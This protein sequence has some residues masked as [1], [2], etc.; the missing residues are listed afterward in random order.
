ML[1][2][3]KKH[4]RKL[5]SI[6]YFLSPT[7]L[8]QKTSLTSLSKIKHGIKKCVT[9][10]D[11]L[12]LSSDPRQVLQQVPPESS[13]RSG[14][15][16]FL[17]SRRISTHENFEKVDWMICY[18]Y[19]KHLGNIR[20]TGLK[21]PTKSNSKTLVSFILTPTL[22]PSLD[23]TSGLTRQILI[24]FGSSASDFEPTHQPRRTW[25]GNRVCVLILCAS[26]HSFCKKV[27]YVWICIIVYISIN[28]DTQYIYSRNVQD[29]METHTVAIQKASKT[30]A[31]LSILQSFSS[32]FVRVWPLPLKIFWVSPK[33]WNLSI[34]HTDGRS[35]V[36]LNINYPP[37]K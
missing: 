11:I 30:S 22:P 27:E 1:Q 10:F 17:F 24:L 13:S 23:S 18:L 8:K 7:I 33:L 34:L 28:L 4:F 36:T 20:S 21:R 14:W 5:Y 31:F 32:L 12:L 16:C 6:R 15:R 37:W 29:S 35:P 3:L 9:K 25:G 26:N 19:P 2:C